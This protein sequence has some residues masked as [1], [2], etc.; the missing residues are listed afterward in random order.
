MISDCGGSGDGAGAGRNSGGGRGDGGRSLKLE[1][2][3][4]RG[5]E[6]RRQR[7]R[8]KEGA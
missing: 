1:R 5:S 8:K 3:S 4:V 7:E 2:A 6:K